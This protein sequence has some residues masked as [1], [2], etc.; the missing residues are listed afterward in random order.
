MQQHSDPHRLSYLR[1]KGRETKRLL[2]IFKRDKNR[3][4]KLV[5]KLK[6]DFLL[7]IHKQKLSCGFKLLAQSLFVDTHVYIYTL[8]MRLY[9]QTCLCTNNL[10][11]RP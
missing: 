5:H 9:A 3:D 10:Q 11:I 7:Q 2:E 6:K 8:C 4:S 1:E